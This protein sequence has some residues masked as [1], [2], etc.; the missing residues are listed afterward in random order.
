MLDWTPINLKIFPY[1]NIP[2]HIRIDSPYFC[3]AKKYRTGK[4]KNASSITT[5]IEKEK[6]GKHKP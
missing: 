4:I 2:R 1:D 3:Y 6:R 5:Q